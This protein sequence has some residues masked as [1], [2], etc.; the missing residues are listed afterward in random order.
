[1]EDPPVNYNVKLLVL[2]ELEQTPHQACVDTCIPV[3]ISNNTV[4]EVIIQNAEA[5][6]WWMQVE[7]YEILPRNTPQILCVAHPA[8]RRQ[9]N[10]GSICD[11]GYKSSIRVTHYNTQKSSHC[12]APIICKRQLAIRL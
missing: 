4:H 7:V 3:G 8:T 10:L 1:M 12:V 9:M 11:K 2:I 5:A 6:Y